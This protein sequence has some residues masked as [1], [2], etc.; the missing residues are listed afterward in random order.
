MSSI[1]N[2]LESLDRISATTESGPFS[3]GAK[4]PR[5]GSVADLADKKRREQE[6][7]RPPIEP[8]DQM[9]GTAKVI[10]DVNEGQLN[11]LAPGFSGDGRWYTDYEIA[12]IVGE[13]WL[14]DDLFSSGANMTRYG[15]VG[16][17]QLKQEA[18]EYLEEQ[19]YSIEV[20]DVRDDEDHLSWLISGPMMRLGEQGVAE[21]KSLSKK[22]KVVKGEHSGKVGWI[23]EIKHGA[24]KGA[25]KTFYVDLEDGTQLNN[26]PGSA[27]RLV[28]DEQG[29]AEGSEKTFTVVYYSKKTDRNVTKQIKASS[30]SE[31]WDRLRA[32]GIDVVSVEEQGVAEDSLN[33]FAP[34][35]DFGGSG[36][37]YFQELA[38]AWYNGIYDTGDI[39]KGIKSQEDVERLLE[40]G[41]ICPDGVTR[42]FHIDYNANYDGVV[43][44]SDDYYEYGDYN[45]AGQIINSR[46]GKKWGPYDYMEFSDKELNESV[47]EGLTEGQITKTKTGIIH[48]ATDKYGAGEEPFNPRN[49]GK[50]ARDINYL[51]KNTTSRLDKGMGIKHSHG[52]KKSQISLELD[53]EQTKFA[54]EKVGQKPGDQVRGT[55]RARL[56]KKQ[57]PFKGRLVGSDESVV[58]EEKSCNYTMEGEDCPVHGLNE[59]PMSENSDKKIIDRRPVSESLFKTLTKLMHEH[60]TSYKY[61]VEGQF[62]SKQEVIDYFIKKGKSAASGAMAWERGWRGSA[63]KPK[64]VS[65]PVRN[66]H[67]ELDD[68]RYR[69]VIENTKKIKENDGVSIGGVSQTSG[70]GGN[71]TKNFQLGPL[72]ASQT[73]DPSGNLVKT[74]MNAK[75]GFGNDQTNIGTER[76]YQS[77]IT[78]KTASGAQADNILGT[79]AVGQRMG[80]DTQKL[81]QFMKTTNEHKIRNNKIK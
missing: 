76:D 70:P 31:L 25:P 64:K 80:V 77:G 45:D 56:S 66:Y 3:Y 67:D 49:P 58:H 74:T 61:T 72:N 4:K 44:F 8:K 12:D 11:E 9:V 57:H 42:K 27:L 13:D 21:A 22:V 78:T 28:K 29:V 40:R 36:G 71:L 51:D 2:L 32:K 5:K 38:S 23:R 52:N 6:K 69:D 7:S 24:F 55:E 30:E 37:N 50:Y 60:E 15:D 62:N 81:D 14:S 43:I 73:T 18:Q 75:V 1:R 19:G 47:E 34:S 33:E 65:A 41:I 48:R 63:P 20:L 39:D 46:T 16:K 17:E 54:G 35:P 79:Q 26:V 53:E 68:K 59:C 10:K